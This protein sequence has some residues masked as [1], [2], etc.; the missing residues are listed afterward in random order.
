MGQVYHLLEYGC[1]AVILELEVNI[2]RLSSVN[3]SQKPIGA[4]SFLELLILPV[5]VFW[6]FC[7]MKASP[8]PVFGKIAKWIAKRDIYKKAEIAIYPKIKVEI[9]FKKIFGPI[10]FDKSRNISVTNIKNKKVM[11]VHFIERVIPVKIIEK[12]RNI[13]FF[14]FRLRYS[15]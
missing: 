5:R 2:T 11:P 1:V 12:A 13:Y 10:E 6:N 15:K 8:A 4:R 9:F 3:F 14:V 7:D